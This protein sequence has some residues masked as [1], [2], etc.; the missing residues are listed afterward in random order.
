MVDLLDQAHLPQ[1][2]RRAY[3]L[4]RS[5]VAVHA[6]RMVLEGEDAELEYSAELTLTF[7]L[8]QNATEVPPSRD[9]SR[10]HSPAG[11]G[12]FVPVGGRCMA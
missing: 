7:G 1:S 11:V 10:R 9:D 4:A 6:A 5:L 2:P 3:M 12:D 8:P